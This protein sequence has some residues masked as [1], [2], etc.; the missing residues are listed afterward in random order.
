[1]IRPEVQRVLEETGVIPSQASK[2][3]P[4]QLNNAGLGIEGLLENLSTL[5]VSSQSDHLKLRAI[6]TALKMQ[7]VLKDQAAPPPSVS[8][9]IQD[10]AGQTQGVNPIFLPRELLKQHAINDTPTDTSTSQN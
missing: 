4:S 9:V 8:I 2:D 1:M 7:G 10:A 6:E 5:M 3:L